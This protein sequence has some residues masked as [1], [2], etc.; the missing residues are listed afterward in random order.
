MRWLR[1]FETTTCPAAAKACSISVATDAS[2]AENTIRG[3]F[4]GSQACT[5]SP[6]TVAGRSPSSR[7]DVASEYRLPADLSLAP[8]HV[9]IEPRMVPK[10]LHKV[11]ANH[12][13]CAK[14]TDLYLLL[15]DFS[16]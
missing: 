14:Y 10:K 9:E 15:H 12:S 7:H 8:T 4:P 1:E 16:R 11:L 13:G 5:C 3:A 6:A 2:I